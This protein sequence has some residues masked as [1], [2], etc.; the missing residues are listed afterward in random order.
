MPGEGAKVPEGAHAD[1]HVEQ[2]PCSG[3]GVGVIRTKH[4]PHS[5]PDCIVFTFSVAL[6][7]VFHYRGYCLG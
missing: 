3:P 7:H 6:L 1:P 4:G 5:L 2:P